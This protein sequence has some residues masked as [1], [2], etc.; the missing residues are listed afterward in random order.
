MNKV[1]EV[2][3]LIVIPIGCLFAVI[4]ILASIVL[5]FESNFAAFVAIGVI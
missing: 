2:F 1:H 5:D 4:S 3:P